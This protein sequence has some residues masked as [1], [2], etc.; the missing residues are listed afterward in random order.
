YVI[1]PAVITAVAI[2]VALIGF[3]VR[4]FKFRVHIDRKHTS[5]ASDDRSARSKAKPKPVAK[6]NHSEV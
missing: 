5:Y 1:V 4:R 3:L 6:E 2:L